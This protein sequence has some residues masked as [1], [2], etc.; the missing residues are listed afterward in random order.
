MEGIDGEFEDLLNSL[1][2]MKDYLTCALED[3]TLDVGEVLLIREDMVLLK[4][5]YSDAVGF[6][7]TLITSES[8][9]KLH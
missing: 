9:E 6:L 3:G 7:D 5:M 4:T 2:S 1:Q 8:K